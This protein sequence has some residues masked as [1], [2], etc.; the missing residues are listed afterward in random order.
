MGIFFSRSLSVV[1]EDVED[2]ARPTAA[3]LAA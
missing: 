1:L 3:P 2:L